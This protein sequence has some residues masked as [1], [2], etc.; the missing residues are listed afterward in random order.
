MTQLVHRRAGGL[1]FYLT[2]LW[3]AQTTTPPGNLYNTSHPLIDRVEGWDRLTGLRGSDLTKRD[4]QVRLQRVLTQLAHHDLVS[5][6]PRRVPKRY[7]NFKLLTDDRGDKRYRVPSHEQVVR[8]PS[9]LITNG[10]HLVLEPPEI[11]FMLMLFSADQRFPT[12]HYGDDGVGFA[13][14]TR[15]A[16]YGMTPEVYE[17]HN[18]LWEFGLID[19]VDSVQDRK[20][21]RV[22][23]PGAGEP[24]LVTYG[25]KLKLTTLD[26]PAYDVVH[27]TLTRVDG[28]RHAS[29]PAPVDLL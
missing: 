15:R 26:H 13:P 18:E 27:E 11:A 1:A 24:P 7:E 12:A 8:V 23:P 16:V 2:A 10:W 25:F 28:G 17:V 29:L 22:A 6:P 21:G 4:R 5:L 14:S 20:R 3:D 9:T 19:R